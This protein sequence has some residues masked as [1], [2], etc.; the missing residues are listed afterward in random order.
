MTATICPAAL[1]REAMLG[2]AAAVQPAVARELL[3]HLPSGEGD[4]IE[5]T[6]IGG[7]ERTPVTPVRHRPTDEERAWCAEQRA[8][9]T[10]PPR[11]E[12]TRR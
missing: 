5:P 12:G 1:M 8:A 11:N 10:Q 4:H 7:I 9:M 3:A 2:L 6:P